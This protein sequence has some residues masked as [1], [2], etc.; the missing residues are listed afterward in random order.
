MN[1]RILVLGATGNIGGVLV[2]NLKKKGADFA[3]G[4][5]HAEMAKLSTLNVRGIGLDF[6]DPDSLDKAMSGFTSVFMLVPMNE[7]MSTWGKNIIEAAKRSGVTFVLR[8]SLIDSSPGSEHMMYR[9][10]GQLDQLLRDSGIGFSIVHP[11][12]FMQNFVVYSA[13]RINETGSV[14]SSHG[15]SKISYVDVRDIAA[16]DAEILVNP[17]AHSGK[18]YTVTGPTALNDTE[19]ADTLSRASGRIITAVS[20][21]EAEYVERMRKSGTPD[22]Y[23]NASMSFEHHIEEGKQA[24]VSGDV[25][26]VTGKA[27]VSFEQ[28]A[29]DYAET[30][31]KV[32]AAV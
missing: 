19:V 28:F 31:R 13:R 3:A 22:W 12:S 25:R 32:P 5:P 23:I 10:H 7:K 8:S 27:P 18:E 4:V 15:D 11:N 21:E 29:W 6:G 1:N 30:W 16:V 24:P 2:Q 26:N 9:V 17:Q 20:M 14:I